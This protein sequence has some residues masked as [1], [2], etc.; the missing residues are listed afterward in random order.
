MNKIQELQDLMKIYL[1]DW[2]IV[3]T[4]DY[5]NSEYVDEY[6][7]AREYLSGFTGSAGTLVLSQTEA[8]LWTDGRYFI[9]AKEQLNN[10]GIKL[11]K[12]GEP[13][14]PRIR[15]FIKANY[16]YEETLGFDGRCNS[17]YFIESI[18]KECPGLKVE[19]NEDLVNSIWDDRPLMTCNEVYVLSDD[20]TGESYQSK[21]KRV[22]EKMAVNHC[23]HMLLTKLDDIMWLFN[24]RGSDIMYNPVA[25][26]FAFISRDESYIF[27]RDDSVTDKLYTYLRLNN[28]VIM[29]YFKIYEFLEEH[30]FEKNECVL[31][32]KYGINYKC[33]T[34]LAGNVALEEDKEIIPSMK[35]VKNSVET[36][37]M[38]EA[39]LEDSVAVTKFLYWL[40][41][42]DKTTLTE[43]KA[44]K[45]LDDLRS[46][47]DGFTDLSF[48][49]ISAYK[50]NGAIV[51]YEPTEDSDRKLANEG[52]LLV[53]SGGQYLKAT[54]D[55]TRT[56][57]LGPISEEEKH[58]FTLVAKGMLNLMNSIF[59][60]GCTGRN[61]DIIAREAMWREGKDYNHGTGHGVGNFL[62]VHEGPVN[63]RYRYIP[64]DNE[65]VLEKGMTVTDEPGLYVEGKY[66]IRTE[67]TLLVTDAEYEGFLR[68][69]PLTYVPID[70][71]GIDYDMLSEEDIGQLNN[72]NK[73]VYEKISPKL[74]E[75]EQKWLCEL[76]VKTL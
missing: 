59:K 14:V 34:I 7:K 3:P 52:M 62:N 36:D 63:I 61:L 74:T 44:A 54:T 71:R 30:Y 10:T 29:D 72:Y 9:Q 49:T 69:E 22:R 8:Y 1:Y 27:L 76:T 12:A 33:K 38:R 55:V 48:S 21:I 6:F 5:H 26:A 56:A 32:D 50:S 2:Y 58:D 57:V 66:G 51:H 60:K 18:L 24:L 35:A 11:M 73:E 19:Y 64:G 65:C 53:D 68:F 31:I 39:F 45:Y 4:N 17:A 23:S 13:G 25:M 75:E 41:T 70:T 42:Q 20:I 46:K 67:N 43:L 47:I 15:D 16:K 37:N 28:I 40:D